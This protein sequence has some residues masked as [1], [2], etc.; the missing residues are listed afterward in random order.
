MIS[1]LLWKNFFEVLWL[2]LDK[3]LSKLARIWLTVGLFSAN[4]TLIHLFFVAAWQ[5]S[6]TPLVPVL[7]PSMTGCVISNDPK[8]RSEKSIFASFP[9]ELVTEGSFWAK[10]R[11]GTVSW[12]GKRT[13]WHRE[14]SI[15]DGSAWI[16]IFCVSAHS[17]FSKQTYHVA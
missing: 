13:P 15:W 9:H 5:C 8:K 3:Q 2:F 10:L 1:L 17:S 12:A 7:L 4:L 11:L 16:F 6:D 14:L